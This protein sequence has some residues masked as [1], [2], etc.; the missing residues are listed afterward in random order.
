MPHLAEVFFH[1]QRQLFPLLEEEIGPL[2]KLDQ[3]FCEVISLTHLGRF[4]RRYDWCGNGCHPH[5]RTSLARA[6]IAK[7]VYQFPTTSALI[8]ALQTRPTLRRLCG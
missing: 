8:D 6:F 1:L 3:Q 5:E 2:S 7:H 4:T